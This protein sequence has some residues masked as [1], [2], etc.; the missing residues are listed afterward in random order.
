M[1]PYKCNFSEKPQLFSATTSSLMCTSKFIL[2]YFSNKAREL[3][4]MHQ[5]Y[6]LHLAELY[7]A[8]C[9]T[10]YSVNHRNERR[11]F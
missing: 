6:R 4:V 8:N 2:Y 9:V 3:V 10:F 5:M 1:F 11:K 7:E